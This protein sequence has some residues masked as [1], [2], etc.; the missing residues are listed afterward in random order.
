MVTHLIIYIFKINH[1]KLLIYY[2]I[3]IIIIIRALSSDPSITCIK[4]TLPP[5]GDQKREFIFSENATIYWL[6]CKTTM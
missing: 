6:Q 3:I 1:L 2:I 5:T 4:K